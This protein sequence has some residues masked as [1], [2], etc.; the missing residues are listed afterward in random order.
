MP[1]Q[2]V[3]EKLNDLPARYQRVVSEMGRSGG[4]RELHVR[5]YA[6]YFERSICSTPPNE[7]LSFT[8]SSPLYDASVM[9]GCQGPLSISYS[10][11]VFSFA[12]WA[13]KGL[14]AL[15][16]QPID[17]FLSGSLLGQ[18]YVISTNNATTMT[19]DSFQLSAHE[20]V[21]ALALRVAQPGKENDK[22][23]D[24]YQA[25]HQR[26]AMLQLGTQ[27]LREEDGHDFYQFFSWQ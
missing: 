25:R 22:C 1:G 27:R 21:M 4:R 2:L 26:L 13:T 7:E 16:V 19:R 24:G 15:G 6:T 10:N 12:S 5:P 3:G 14:L 18:S 8:N 11:Y 17:G 20:G 9:G 23:Q